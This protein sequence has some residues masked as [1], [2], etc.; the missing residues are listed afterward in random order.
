MSSIIFF[1]ENFKFRAVFLIFTGKGDGLRSHAYLLLSLLEQNFAYE[2]VVGLRPYSCK[3]SSYY[4]LTPSLTFYG[5]K[6]P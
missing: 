6:L 4:I 1:V 3:T 2:L 5:V